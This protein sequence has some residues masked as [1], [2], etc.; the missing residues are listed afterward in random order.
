MAT[1]Q[2]TMPSSSLGKISRWY[3]AKRAAGQSVK[4]WELEAAYQAEMEALNTQRNAGRSISLN[5]KSQAEQQALAQLQYEL[6]AKAQGEN[7]GLSKEQFAEAKRMNDLQTELRR[8]ELANQSGHSAAQL[9][10]QAEQN[11]WQQRMAVEAEERAKR[12]EARQLELDAFEKKRYEDTTAEDRRRYELNLQQQQEDRDAA[13][14]SSVMGSITS[15]IPTGLAIYALTKG[16][17][18]GV[19]PAQIAQFALQ[20]KVTPDVAKQ[21]LTSSIPEEPGMF[22]KAYTGIKNFLSPN[23]PTPPTTPAVPGSPLTTTAPQSVIPTTQ[24]S[25]SPM[26]TEPFTGG[27]LDAMGSLGNV[28]TNAGTSTGYS[29]GFDPSTGGPGFDAYLG[30][31]P[32]AAGGELGGSLANY[33]PG[34]DAYMAD[35]AFDY[36]GY[37]AQQ[38]IGDVGAMGTSGVGG[39]GSTVGGF[40]GS[41]ASGTAAGGASALGI[42]GTA[43]PYIA[44]ARIGMPILGNTLDQVHSWFGIDDP[45]SSNVFAQLARVTEEDYMRPI[46]ALSSR[47]LGVDIP[48]PA[49][50]IFN[51]AGQ[52][53]KS[54]CIIVTACTSPDSEEVNI[55]REYRDKFLSPEQLRGYY[56]IAEKIVPLIE[57]FS[58]VKKVVKRVLVDNLIEYGRHALGKGKK[59]SFVSVIVTRLFLALCAN[60]GARRKQFVRCNGEVV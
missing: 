46:E 58:F 33:G 27:E 22:S 15:L 26:P 56:V 44:A 14:K 57:R 9:A 55:T 4:P 12:M 50:W 41:G 13:G 29:M 47:F 45:D 28:G 37:A 3:N 54:V 51:P 36:T 23:T 19:T 39:G 31:T 2:Y 7:M 48:E 21:M 8:Q 32:S 49:Q 52:L 6:A 18:G 20:N 30:N 5:E 60:V 34:V 16:M 25:F 59:P 24:P 42:V 40:F 1:M 35:P 11:E 17:G 43:A 53:M 10:M 38:G